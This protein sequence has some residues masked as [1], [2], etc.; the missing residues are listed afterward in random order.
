[1][2]TNQ[3]R[4]R[5]S[6]LAAMLV[7]AAGT[8]ANAQTTVTWTGGAGDGNYSN[9]LNWNPNTV[10]VNSGTNL[11]NVVIPF[12]SGRTTIY[13]DAATPADID[14]QDLT[15]ADG[16]TMVLTP[17]RHVRVRD[18]A[19]LNGIID[20]RGIG[21]TFDSGTA[22]A[23]SS[24]LRLRARDSATV[25]LRA[26]S[27]S[28]SGN[29]YSDTLLLADNGGTIK[30]A[31]TTQ[32]IYGA[33]GGRWTHTLQASLG[34]SLD[35]GDLVN[36]ASS[37]G[38]DD[39]LDFN[40]SENSSLNLS[41]LQVIAANGNG[42]DYV[43][44]SLGRNV[45][46]SAP[47]LVNASRLRTNFSQNASFSAPNLVSLTQ[48]QIALSG[49]QSFTTGNL[50]NIDSSV[51]SVSGGATFGANV[52]ATSYQSNGSYEI[53]WND[54]T[55]F[56]ADGNNSLLRLDSLQNIKFGHGSGRR[57]QYITADNNGVVRFNGLSS[58]TTFDGEDDVLIIRPRTGGQVLMPS[59]ASISMNGNTSNYVEYQ[60]GAGS[61]QSLP[62]LTSASQ[63]YFS[64]AVGAT[65]NVPNLASWTRASI[66]VNATTG[67]VNVGSNV[68][69][70][71]DLAI[72]VADG[73]TFGGIT[74][75]LVALSWR[76][77]SYTMYSADG[78]GSLLDLRGVG[79]LRSGTGGGYWT[80]TITATNGGAINLA[81]LQ[82]VAIGYNG[83]DDVLQFNI[84]SGGSINLN[85]LNTI[86][87]TGNGNDYVLF[88]AAAN[89]TYSLPAATTVTRLRTGFSGTGSGINAPNLTSLTQSVINLGAG[90]FFNGGNAIAQFDNSVVRVSG[91][92][93][94]SGVTDTAYRSDAYYR[95]LWSGGTVFSADGAG[96]SVLLPSIQD[97]VYG[98][99][100]G[101]NNYYVT[102]ANG[103]VV[104]LSGLRTLSILGGQD[105]DLYFQSA[106]TGGQI[107]LDNLRSISLAGN[108]YER[109]QFDV[110]AGQTQNLPAL[111]SAN[112][113]Y[114]NVN[115]GS[116]F[117]AP[118]LTSFTQSVFTL[119]GGN[120]VAL[121][122]LTD[123][124]ASLFRVSGGSTLSG[125]ADA[126]YSFY[127]QVPSVWSGATL[128]SADGAGSVLDARG[129]RLIRNGQQ[130]GRLGFTISASNGGSINLS[131][132]NAITPIDGQDDILNLSISNGGTMDLSGLVNINTANSG[133][134]NDY[135][136]FTAGAGTTFDLPALVNARRTY[137]SVGAGATVN[138]PAMTSLTESLVELGAFA[139]QTFTHGPLSNING[140][141]IR[142]SNGVVFNNITATS[143]SF[144]S[145]I[146]PLWSGGT[147]FSA[148][149]AGSRI[150]LST[151]ETITNGQP[152]G[153]NA[154]TISATNGGVVNLS[155]LTT[156][157]PVSGQDDYLIFA[158]AT[159]GSINLSSLANINQSVTGNGYEFVYFAPG[160]N[161]AINVPSLVNARRTRYSLPAG[162]SFNAPNLTSLTESIVTVNNP[163][164]FNAPN[165]TN[166]DATIINV[167]NGARFGPA[168]DTFF[169]QNS[170]V[171]GLFN[172]S[173]VS[174][175]TADGA[176][177]LLD[178]SGVREF[179]LGWDWGNTTF[180]VT[181]SNT[182]AI[183]LSG[184]TRI[185][186]RSGQDD[187]LA[188]DF[189]SGG[190]INLAS[191]AT[192]DL[193]GGNGNQGVS[194]NIAAGATVNLPA[195]T[196]FNS[197]SFNLGANS[198]LN[199]PALRSVGFWGLT[200]ANGQQ[201]RTGGLTNINNS[202]F[203]I[204][205]GIQWGAV[206]GDVLATSYSTTGYRYVNFNVFSA[207]NPGSLLDL[208]SVQ[209]MDFAWNDQDGTAYA[210]TISA[211]DSG[212][213][214]LR[215]VTR[216]TLPAR[217][218]DRVDFVQ[219]TGGTINLAGLQI[220]DGAGRARFY[221]RDARSFSLPSL[222]QATGVEFDLAAGSNFSAPSLLKLNFSSITIP[223][224]RTVRLGGLTDMNNSQFYLSSGQRW[225]V[226]TGDIAAT[227]Y[228]TTGYRYGN[229]TYFSSTGTGSIL[230][231]SSIQSGNFGWDDAD[232]TTYAGTIS[233]SLNG[234]VDLSGLQSITT[235]A[236]GEDRLDLVLATGGQIRLNSLQT[237]SGG[238]LIRFA[239]S[240]GTSF[241]L[242][243]LTTLRNARFDLSAGS[244]FSAPR[245]Q[246]FNFSSLAITQGRT[247]VF[248]G[249][250]NI[251]NSDIQTSSGR[252][253]GTS[254]GDFAALNYSRT[255]YR[256]GNGT[257]FSAS[258]AGSVLDLSSLQTA[259][260][261]WDDQDGTVYSS[262]ISASN[263]GI[264][265]L[266][267]LSTVT[268]PARGEDRLDFNIASG[269]QIRLNSLTTASG[270]GY[271]RFTAT[272]GADFNLPNLATLRNG[273]FV[274]GPGSDFIAP[275]LSTMNFSGIS[276]GASNTVRMRLVNA[277]NSQI[278]NNSGRTWGASTGDFAAANYTTNGYRYGNF[279]YFGASGVNST[280]DLSTLTTL[281]ASWNDSDGN[282]YAGNVSASSDGRVNL[283]RLRSIT[284]PARGEDRID[285]IASTD[286]RIDFGSV[287]TIGGGGQVRFRAD[288]GGTLTFTDLYLPSNS[289]LT[290]ADIDSTATIAK[291]LFLQGGSLVL[292]PGA[293][294]TINK[295]FSNTNTNEASMDATNAIIRMNGT[296]LQFLEAAG[297]DLGPVSPGNS[298]NFG[299]GQLI[300]GDVGHAVS[301]EL[302]DLYDNG[303]RGQRANEA[304]YLFGL[305][306]PQGLVL[307]GGSTLYIDNINVYARQDGRWVYLNGLFGPGDSVIAY[308]GGYLHLPSP[309]ALG[310]FGLAGLIAARRRRA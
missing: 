193:T 14:I 208:S 11:Y 297:L 105:D 54:A 231:L 260:F 257:I 280:L 28:T 248:G 64:P 80:H 146:Y 182:G 150:D 300:V 310:V 154:F 299:I 102:V 284:A 92:A 148:D 222:A 15:L 37:S 232:G 188:F 228:S 296:G 69:Q 74:D 265:D 184:L 201:F 282:A 40:I 294:L 211:T 187:K 85:G 76:T 5:R 61:T 4:I 238:G 153:R 190:T 252:A 172:T 101:D 111:Q 192:I 13:F 281:D 270:G 272:D 82:S 263:S 157:N 17:N 167:S 66:A 246:N 62:A 240:D 23:N 91:G 33:G 108:N 235:P 26:P 84:A 166:L 75:P 118:N 160:A 155:G 83:D 264:V 302:T 218:E 209:S 242:P 269:G 115:A 283:S 279:T 125:I 94:F 99:T 3:T 79:G 276:I 199:L 286:G 181:A 60:V 216:F 298:G 162:S 151:I 8:V 217:G 204:R 243:A 275:S 106:A 116:T 39:I 198:I 180:R 88:S 12:V 202:Q 220:I 214:D 293:Q 97:W 224:D 42:N 233:A 191:L 52:T 131:G 189:N 117:T 114:V 251:D 285:F 58:L 104:D 90:Q 41:R 9:P 244:T 44:L 67:S 22:V 262:V 129:I 206:S 141:S 164:T 176:G 247:F 29:T 73:R 120:N 261:G 103:G 158:P 254:T 259:N 32:Y 290:V 215:N 65:V 119:A 43:R 130:N 179:R 152:G 161:T 212:V 144:N 121:S 48:S 256:Y 7:A 295:N 268:P 195:L 143:Y 49:T 10:P 100:N 223:A 291:T 138:A 109:V 71:D 36:L 132:L 197:T 306:G 292:A 171:E 249:V 81:G 178:L 207:A 135:V 168:G 288:T 230:D 278:I 140:T 237:V 70:A 255:G 50:A 145:Q 122:S 47:A 236:R 186:M 21:T 210:S 139:N 57:V 159:G 303:N 25:T 110:G 89:H 113:T 18:D 169:E 305:G 34:G 245:L 63:T 72:S 271:I 133:N 258:G 24:K 78:A 183:D 134:G 1:M 175:W 226:S 93:T 174:L 274:L 77:W 219:T 124:D 229:F 200:L 156:I 307:M 112:R 38:E 273:Q 123:V 203:N 205:S 137:Y 20:A 95:E 53:L 126:D 239:T 185:S 45:A 213:V 136:Q 221:G 55:L 253:W 163:G 241:S 51:F 86:T 234:I 87:S 127:V 170:Y 98:S 107:K 309:G 27:M 173:N 2:K 35:M 147:L 304:L 68:S 165:I 266:S 301:V 128:F 289:L 31:G 287:R 142:V 56:A 308:S 6:I 196:T 194:F 96:S 19:V 30:L 267:G 16:M 59:L 46:V 227:T 277:D 250:T 177:T 225:G 149:G